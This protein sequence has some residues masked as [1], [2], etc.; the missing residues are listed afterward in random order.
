[1][2]GFGVGVNVVLGVTD[3]DGVLSALVGAGVR[4]GALVTFGVADGDEVGVAAAGVGV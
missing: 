4:V 1:M 2:V 3:A